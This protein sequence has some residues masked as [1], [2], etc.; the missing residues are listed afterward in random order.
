MNATITVKFSSTVQTLDESGNPSGP[1]KDV[2]DGP[3]DILMLQYL[4]R[5]YWKYQAYPYNIDKVNVISLKVLTEYDT[6]LEYILSMKFWLTI[7]SVFCVIIFILKYILKQSLIAASLEFLRTIIGTSTLKYPQQ[8]SS[9]IFFIIL[10]MSLFILSSMI[11]CRLSAV[12]TAPKYVSKIDSVT[13]LLNAKNPIFGITTHKKMLFYDSLRQRY[14][15]VQDIKECSKR[16]LKRNPII[17]LCPFSELGFY[18][19]ESRLIHIAKDSII[20]RSGTFTLAKDWPL[21]YKFNKVL[22]GIHKGGIFKLFQ[23]R[24]RDRFHL[25][26]INNNIT[27][28]GLSVTELIISFYT[29]LGGWALASLT[30]IIESILFRVKKLIAHFDT[31]ASKWVAPRLA[32]CDRTKRGSQGHTGLQSPYR[33]YID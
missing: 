22:A 24:E 7:L 4:T 23:E 14:H 33:P 15:N 20:E 9:R 5:D 8:A 29:L 1:T 13:D 11:Q 16:L 32:V 2:L 28:E 30:F 26:H 12:S 6:E 21:R 3:A 17:C 18:F 27:I 19:Y 31:S 10:V 25:K